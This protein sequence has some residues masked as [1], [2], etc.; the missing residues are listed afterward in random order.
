MTAEIETPTRVPPLALPGAPARPD[1][2]GLDDMCR[3]LE[4]EAAA[5]EEEEEP[6][7]TG[8]GTADREKHPGNAILDRAA[9]SPTPSPARTEVSRGP[10]NASPSPP[11]VT[12]F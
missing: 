6:P 9:A 11:M 1:T 3:S 2:S 5:L 10:A 7:G 8:A 4:L 12:H